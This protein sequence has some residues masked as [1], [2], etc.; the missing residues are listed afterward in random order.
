MSKARAR[1]EALCLGLIVGG[2]AILGMPGIGLVPV[3][4]VAVLWLDWQ[5]QREFP[6]DR[7]LLIGLGYSTGFLV[8]YY[9]GAITW[10]TEVVAI[11][12]VLL[13]C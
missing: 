8:P 7:C 6:L 3:Y 1:L 2:A 11:P 13:R 9:L 12:I 10:G 4:F 5:C